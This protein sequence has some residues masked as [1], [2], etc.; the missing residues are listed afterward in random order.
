MATHDRGPLPL[1]PPQNGVWFA[2]QLDPTRLDYTI[3]EYLE[4]RG[5]VDPELLAE[6]VRTMVAGTESLCVRF[7]EVDGA[8]CQI[9]A[10]PPP[11]RLRTVDVSGHPDP[12]GESERLMRAELARPTDLTTGDVCRFLLVRTGPVTYRWMQGYHHLVADGVTG[13]MLARRTAE[14]YSALVA[15]EPVPA[16]ESAPWEPIVAEEEEYAGSER[17]VQDREFWLARLDGA[18][19]PVSFTGSAPAP[20]SGTAVRVSGELDPAD[21]RTLREAARRHG[22][23]WSALVMAAAAAHLHRAGTTED[24]VLGLPVTGRTTQ[25]ARRTPGMFSKV[26]PL[27][28]TVTGDTTVG[29][30]VRSTSAG[31]KEALRHQRYRIEEYTGTGPRLWD[32]AVNLMSFDYELSFAGAPAS[33]HNLAVGPVE[34]VSL[35]VYDR[36]GDSPLTV[37]AEGDAADIGPAEL[38]ALRVRFTR[39]LLALAA[40]D[41]GAPV[42]SLPFLTA[43]DAERLGA[44]AEGG[45]DCAPRGGLLHALFE[46]VAARAPE[47]VAVVCAGEEVTYRELDSWAQDIADRLRPAVEPGT[48]VGVCVERSPAMVA[49]LLGVLKAGGCYVPLDPGLP[50]ERIA[51]V[52]RDAGLRTV[53][54]GPGSRNRLPHDLPSVVFAGAVTDAV[55]GGRAGA[56]VPSASAAYLLYT[57]GST[58]EPKGVVVPHAAAVD[59]VRGHLALCG[60]GDTA[61]SGSGRT[62]R[63][64]GFASLSFDVSVL[65]VF[66]SLLSG[67]TLVLATDAER[68]D[69]DRLQALLAEHAVTVADLPPALLPLL[70]PAALPELRFLSTGGEAPSGDAVDRWAV[71]GREVWNAYGPT[72]AAVSVT[73][74]RVVPPS[75]GRIP[76]IGRP[77]ANHRAYVVDRDLRLLPP[78][79]T[80]ELCVAGAGL[81][82]GYAGRAAMTADRFVPDP[83]SDVP[84]ARMY[85]TGDLVRWSARGELEFLGRVDR[86]VKINGHRIELGEIEAVLGRQSSVGQAAVIV[87]APAGGT[88]R[89]VA[90]VAPPQDGPAPDPESLTAELGRVLPGYMVP[91]TIVAVDRLPLT[92]GGKVDRA[93]LRVPEAAARPEHAERPYG[94][95]ELALAAL[96]SEALGVTAAPDDNFFELGGDSITALTLTSRARAH[97]FSFTLRDVFAHKTA[98]ALAAAVGEPGTGTPR[99]AAPALD[100][101]GPLP[102]TPVM[103][104]LLDGPGPVGRFSQSMVLALPEGADDATLVRVLQ[105]VVDRH[106]ALRLGVAAG[107][108]GPLCTVGEPGSVDVSRLYR[109]VDVTGPDES[110]RAATV[111]EAAREAAGQLDPAA[112]VMLRAVHFDAGG[113]SPDRLLLC[114]HHLAVD[115]VSWR[116][117]TADLAAA[118]EAAVAGR[119]LP[120]ADG[121]VS[122]RAWAHHLEQQAHAPEVLA[123]LPFWRSA[124]ETAGT[125]PDPQAPWHRVPDPARDTAGTTRT[126]TLG[127]PSEVAGPL[128]AR[129]PGALR[130]GPTEV[131]LAGLV[132]AAHRLRSPAAAVGPLLVDLEGHGR[133]DRTGRHDL[134]RTVGWFTTQY[135]VRFDLDGLDLD[136]AA[137]GGDALAELVARIHTVVASVPDHGTGFGLLSRLNP[138]TAAEL[139]ALPR[140]R[141]LFNYLG[142]FS[143]GDEAPWSPAPEAGGLRADVDPAMPVEHVLQIDAMAV[144]GADGPSFTAVVTHP[145]ALLTD[146]ETDE[147]VAAWDE[148]L[149]LLATWTGAARPRRLTP[150]DLPLVRLTQAETDALSARHAG[151]VDVL[152]LSPLQEGLFFHSAFDTGAMDAYTGQLVLTLDGPVDE[153]ALRTACDRLLRRHSA[154]RSAFTDQGLDR[155]VQ[156]VLESVEAPWETV[157]LGGLGTAEGQREWERLLAADR[158]RRFDLERPPLVRFTL[159]RF[160]GDVHRLVMTNHHIL[161]DGWSSAVLLRELLTGYA[162]HSACGASGNPGGTGP[163]AEGV[164]YRA[165]LDWL[166]RQDHG[167]AEAA[168]SGAL[169]GLE[170]PTLLGAADPNRIDDLPER[171]SVELSAELTARLTARARTAGVTLNSVVQGLWAVLLGRVTGRDDVVFG[172]TV[173]GRTA[174]VAGIE[175]MVGLLINTLPVRFRIREDEPLLAALARFQDEQADLMDHQHVGLAG[176]Q[177]AAGLGTLFD[178]TVVVENYPLDL[179]SM[180]DLA[181]GPRLTGVEGSDATHYTVNLIVLPG[182]RL[183]LHLDHRTDVLDARTARSLGEALERLLTAVA[184]APATPVG[185]VDLL[186][187]EQHRLIREWNGTAVPVP[188]TTLV[189]LFAQQVA[190]TPG[191]PATV[192]RDERLSYAELDARAERLARELRARGA[193]P[194]RIVAVALHR[195]T[196]MVVSLLAVL[197][198]G[199]AYLP[200]DPSLPADRIAYLLSDAEPVLLLADDG[201]AAA[202]PAVADLP[203][204]DPG[205]AVHGGSG[206]AAGQA[207]LPSHPAYVIYTSGSTGRP[208]AVVVEHAA[209]VNR[210]LW[211]QDR[212]RL[213]ADDRVLQKTPF[214]FD[215]S[216]WEFFWPLLTGA[217]LVV[218]EPGGH[219]D[220]S[221]LTRVIQEESI[222]TVHFVPSM[223]AA[224]VE[225]P[226]AGRCRSLRRVVCSGEALPEELKN[227]F[228]DVLDVPLHNLYGPTEAAVDVTHWDCRREETGPVPIGRP[229]WNTSLY[230]LDPRGRPVPVGVAGELFLAGAGLARGYLRRPAL[231][232]ERFP[233]DPFGP[234]GSR[235]YR[236]GDLARHRADGSVEY[237]GRTDDQVKIH[238]F[239]IELGEIETALG[240]LPGVGRAAVVVREDVPGERRLVG[241]LVPEAG[242]DGSALPPDPEPM[243]AELARSLP[244][245]MVPVLV[246]VDGLPVTAN[247]KLDRRALPA[248]AATAAATGYEP[249]AGE[250][251]ELVAMVWASVLDAPRIGRHDDFFAL[252]GHSLSATRVAARLRQ[253]LGLDLP[254]HTLFEQRTVAALAVAVET[255]LLAE[256]EA[257]AAPFD[258]HTGIGA[259]IGAETATATATATATDGATDGVPSLVLQGETS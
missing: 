24:V 121:E 217:A 23:R 148:A 65:D 180:R 39:F 21:A 11:L 200:V 76:P 77:M 226:Q 223:L 220:P 192:F 80:G 47:S 228:L 165:H 30:L 179:E 41:D 140:P 235:M 208:K 209:I 240:R 102:A 193:G 96:F 212:Y 66:G 173:S 38:D 231:T 219:K 131:L 64:L 45:G 116:I 75:H 19:D 111:A 236:T 16:P 243:R 99:A 20:A 86:Q 126:L 12:D 187:E 118:W 181:G 225:D 113:A 60:A 74:H 162:E 146:A 196:E 183:R 122:F 144:D 36:G 176:I 197:K 138:Q 22:T 158:A 222:T 186:S 257:E 251:E 164:P 135:P 207:P 147:L 49:A 214:G 203:R 105:S 37:Q 101:C 177:R 112:S 56:V 239:R 233:L 191:A 167:A 172:G 132:L 130:T 253:A 124:L 149:R 7:A 238:G 9:P 161:W 90:F 154:L 216:V 224:F 79:A 62:E 29:E 69:V 163:I 93:R 178:T 137:R 84:G 17:C 33:A 188:G 142:R 28:L 35:N 68:V 63:F 27:R 72:E 221:Y 104:W 94:A 32:A 249:P 110:A 190:R 58:G 87:H 143:G 40:A 213:G 210:L 31:I 14:V 2:Q 97:G 6:A 95:V 155:P 89:L 13:P 119:P 26:L 189:E 184:D 59:F 127:L 246:F 70:D 169:A 15:G 237:L 194:E 100:A 168:W 218:A 245:Y 98:A 229:I 117:L 73:M 114:V 53:V 205:A 92:P 198:S 174:D 134:A 152:P 244:E 133:A 52:V 150:R 5:A 57:S 201:V 8:V 195:S 153:R 18:P 82:Q 34:H 166:A 43:E 250:T 125:A 252:G 55:H 78:G 232:A 159:V 139:S 46:E 202:L 42:C 67:S 141:I 83:F 234:P 185:E 145:Q 120:A 71:D 199:A 4:I 109:T 254:L 81:A 3:G 211:M 50:P 106:G 227:R 157:D 215:V 258:A 61:G 156:V 10:G 123:E 248:P 247:G 107:P 170:E 259:G 108:E 129:V 1:T 51:Y 25:D 128:L 256:L 160:G 175:D 91:R 44:L 241:Y 85:R 182:E 171:A 48:P 115:G 242:T 255:V 136:A 54:A 204:L 230:V 88:R 206:G 103:R 151:L